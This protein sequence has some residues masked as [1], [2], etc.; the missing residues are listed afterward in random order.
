MIRE[1]VLD[2]AIRV[3]I[4]GRCNLTRSQRYVTFSC[5][6]YTKMVAVVIK[7]LDIETCFESLPFK[8]YRD[9]Y[10]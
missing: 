4:S 2:P 3:I 9:F 7:P 5:A 8:G 1:H 6:R 10:T